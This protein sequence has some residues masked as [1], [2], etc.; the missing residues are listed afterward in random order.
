MR[1]TLTFK[2]ICVSSCTVPFSIYL[3]IFEGVLGEEWQQ[4]RK[5][6]SSLERAE[7]CPLVSFCMILFA[8]SRA[9]LAM[10]GFDAL[11]AQAIF[12]RQLYLLEV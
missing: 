8:T 11:V 10:H 3:V 2:H 5:L 4:K 6:S 7:Q 9:I 12:V 1:K